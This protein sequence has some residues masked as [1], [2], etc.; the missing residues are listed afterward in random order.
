MPASSYTYALAT[1]EK[2]AQRLALVQRVYGP[3]AERLLDTIGIAEGQRV[4]DVGCGT[5]AMLPWL[6]GR[7]GQRGRVVGLDASA[8][9]LAVA[10]RQCE[11]LGLSQ[12]S[13]V[14][15]DVYATGLPADQFDLAHCRLLLC[16]LQKP[17]IAIAEMA[18]VVRPGGFVVCLD[19]DLEGLFSIPETDC[20]RQMREI[21]V[22]RRT[23]DGLDSRLGLKLPEMMR[24]AGLADPQMA[25][26]HPVY[27]RGEEK[28]L[29]EYSFAESAGRTLERGLLGPE[30]LE[31]LL[32]ELAAVGADERIAAVQATMP[33]CWARKVG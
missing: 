31:A 9:Q 33:V 26:I 15:A 16:H 6:A 19:V 24:G 2:A 29:W 10:R 28:R 30:A 11:A 4:L 18:R 22:R 27:F 17:E 5:G 1:G 8:D 14:A 13:F 7:V 23:L 21:F 25:F 32:Q 3:D 20:Y 12:V